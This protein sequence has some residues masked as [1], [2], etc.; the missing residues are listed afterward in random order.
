MRKP[1]IAVTLLGVAVFAGGYIVGQMGGISLTSAASTG[2]SQPNWNWDHGFNRFNGSGGV[3]G[4]AAGPHA[5]GTVTGINGN[6]VTIKPDANNSDEQESVTT[7]VLT[8]STQYLAGPGAT[9]NKDSIKVGSFI[10]AEGTLSS[11]GKTLTASKVAVGL[12]AGHMGGHMHGGAFG[13][14]HAD[15]T[16]TGISGNNISIKADANHP[17][18]QS[19]VTTVVVTSSTQYLSGLRNSG[20][21]ATKASV[22]V[23][24]FIIA[25]GTL[26]SD[27]KT[28][29]A[30]QVL[31]LPSA[32]TGG[33]HF[34]GFGGFGGFD[35][36][37]QGQSNGFQIGA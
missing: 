8:G 31:V 25:R 20:A 7:I 1:L 32:P 36:R 17:D 13:G 30:T 29:T 12:G 15:G 4:F 16:V 23:G 19:S 2:Q 27:G 6:N 11:D 9:A 37:W 26:S 34:G 28:L 10:I 14:P 5:D 3:P 33:G 24:S 35:N 22:K 21:A 18:E